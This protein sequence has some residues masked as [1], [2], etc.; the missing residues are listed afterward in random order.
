MIAEWIRD[1]LDYGF[2]KEE[3]IAEMR[4]K[5]AA[6]E[7]EERRRDASDLM[8]HE[9]KVRLRTKFLTEPEPA[10]DAWRRHEEA[11]MERAEV[12]WDQEG[13]PI[14][15]DQARRKY[16]AKFGRSCTGFYH[17]DFLHGR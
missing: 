14:P 13:Q 5:K 8:L 11:R 6:A 4:R 15:D 7:E 12:Q 2:S 3:I 1:M 9:I 17:P 16:V 10:R